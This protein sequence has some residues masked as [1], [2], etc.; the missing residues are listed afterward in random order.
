MSATDA[1]LDTAEPPPY[2]TEDLDDDLLPP[3]RRRRLSSLSAVLILVLVAALGVYG[4]VRLQKNR[5]SSDTSG[6]TSLAALASRFAA[7]GGTRTGATGSR[8]GGAGGFAGFGG[9]GAG[10][11]GAGGGATFGTV[12]LVDGDT[13]YVSMSDGSIVKVRT[14]PSGT[15]VTKT[16]P[17]KV[18]D[19]QP[20]ETVVVRGTTASDGTVSAST[21]TD[22]GVTTTP[23]TAAAGN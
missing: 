20:G 10:A 14:T 4:G 23:T 22:S 5:A 19:I 18:G 11:G 3:P 9:A 2:P 17:A 12:K 13:I 8:T 7:A 16:V 21:V 6:T 15:T 1:Q